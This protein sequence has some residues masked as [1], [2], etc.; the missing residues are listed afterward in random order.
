MQIGVSVVAVVVKTERLALTIV[1]TLCQCRQMDVKGEQR[2][3][4]T[5]CSL[6]DFST[7]KTVELIQKAY[8]DAALSRTKIFEWHT[9][10][11]RE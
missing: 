9:N 6:V 7:T 11:S 10:G 5:F 4:I 3:A 1:V 2:V 8:G